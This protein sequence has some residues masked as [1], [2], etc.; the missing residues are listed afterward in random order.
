MDIGYWRYELKCQPTAAQPAQ[1]VS[2]RE[3]ERGRTAF[4]GLMLGT[5][6]SGGAAIILPWPAELDAK[7]FFN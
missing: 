6:F 3:K 1:L 2:R 7:H 4:R 5:V